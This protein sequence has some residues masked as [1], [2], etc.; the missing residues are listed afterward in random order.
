MSRSL[1]APPRRLQSLG[2]TPVDERTQDFAT[3]FT[4]SVPDILMPN[5]QTSSQL[6]GTCSNI[7]IGELLKS[8]KG[9]YGDSSSYSPLSPG[10]ESKAESCELCKIILPSVKHINLRGHPMI[11]FLMTPH[12]LIIEV[13]QPY[14]KKACYGHLR[15]CADPGK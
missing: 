14:S 12:F 6:C 8:T 4:R 15:L 10:R 13:L 3:Y 5:W 11:N 7:P 1:S 2:Y 9:V